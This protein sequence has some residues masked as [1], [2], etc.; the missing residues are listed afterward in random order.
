MHKEHNQCSHATIK[1]CVACDVT[2][3]EGC[4]KEWRNNTVV[5]QQPYYFNGGLNTLVGTTTPGSSTGTTIGWGSGATTGG[6]GYYAGG[7]A[8]AGN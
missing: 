8:S 5:T 7:I 1:H 4:S 3:C 2:Y 6:T